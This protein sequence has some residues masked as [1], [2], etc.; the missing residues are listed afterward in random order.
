M[1]S[2]QTQNSWDLRKQTITLV[3][4]TLVKNDFKDKVNGTKH[5]NLK[6]P[7]EKQSPRAVAATR[8]C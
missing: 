1:N 3:T 2:E 8:C 5:F 4:K 7:V 6:Q